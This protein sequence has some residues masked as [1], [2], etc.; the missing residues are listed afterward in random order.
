MQ[1][2]ANQETRSGR[3][4]PQPRDNKSLKSWMM[5]REGVQ[6]GTFHELF[7]WDTADFK[8]SPAATPT[9]PHISTVHTHTVLVHQTSTKR[10]NSRTVLTNHNRCLFCWHRLR[11]WMWVLVGISNWGNKSWSKAL[12]PGLV[13]ARPIDQFHAYKAALLSN[14]CR[15]TTACDWFDAGTDDLKRQSSTERVFPRCRCSFLSLLLFFFPTGFQSLRKKKMNF[16]KGQHSSSPSRSDL[17][18]GWSEVMCG[19]R[20]AQSIVSASPSQCA[21]VHKSHCRTRNVSWGKLTQ[22]ASCYSFSTAR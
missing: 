14:L 22:N 5:K 18:D 6:K 15:C 4:G 2:P 1:K 17:S 12:K 16:W 7:F 9:D 11:Y 21:H 20:A 13:A 10:D 8:V 3:D 19:L